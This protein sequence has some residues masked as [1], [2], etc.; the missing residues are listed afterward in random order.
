MSAGELRLLW[1][2]RKSSA[3]PPFATARLMRA[4]LAWDMQ[5]EI[6]G[7]ETSAVRRR[8]EKIERARA[9]G[10][11]ASEAIEGIAVAAPVAEGTR[12]IRTWRGRTHDVLVTADG[13]AWR[14]QSYRSLSAVARAITGTS[15]NGP[16]FFGLRAG[17]EGS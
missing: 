14:G 13:V 3:P 9:S 2:A 5:A 6:F 17:G 16:A 12:L 10:A 1:Q 15:R 11:T 8:W 7:G 4:A